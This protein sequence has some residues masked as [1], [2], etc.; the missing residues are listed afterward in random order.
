MG[1]QSYKFLCHSLLGGKIGPSG[2]NGY[3]EQKV[4]FTLFHPHA[5][6]SNGH[7]LDSMI[8]TLT[9]LKEKEDQVSREETLEMFPADHLP[10]PP[11]HTENRKGQAP[12]AYQLCSASLHQ[13]QR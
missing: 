4:R 11:W 13:T 10:V 9:P 5:S 12:H 3:S 8:N 1:V 7:M 6:L 2:T